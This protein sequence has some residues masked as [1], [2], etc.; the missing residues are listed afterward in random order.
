MGCASVGR[1]EGGVRVRGEEFES[2]LFCELRAMGML[3]PCAHFICFWETEVD[4]HRELFF[5]V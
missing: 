3:R 5:D 1:W 4:I 2:G